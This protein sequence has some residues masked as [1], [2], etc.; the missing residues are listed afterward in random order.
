MHA[1]EMLRHNYVG[2]LWVNGRK[3]YMVYSQ[4]GGASYAS[5]NAVAAGYTDQQ[6]SAEGCGGPQA[7]CDVPTPE[8]AIEEMQR[9]LISPDGG[10]GEHGRERIL[11]PGHRTVNIGVAWNDR[12]VVLVQHFEGGAA[13]ALGP[14]I[15]IGKRYLSFSMVKREP[16]FR[17]AGVVSV[18]Y[19]PPPQS[20]S[21]SAIYALASYCTG[22]GPTAECGAPVVRVLPRLEPGHSYTGLE[23]NEVVATDW[24]DSD[25]AFT[26]SA[27]VAHL[28]Q[29]PGVYTVVVWRDRGD[30]GIE[31]KLVELSI[32]VE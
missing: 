27:D 1:D 15:L 17:V 8:E 11:G 6:W 16:G 25:N 13:E 10:L 32:F 21:P 31:E 2:H 9:S 20:I 23:P 29:R 26:F 24:Q 22:G 30:G 19:D 18:F 28:M 5:E 12:R 7:S 4:T 3:P 14:P